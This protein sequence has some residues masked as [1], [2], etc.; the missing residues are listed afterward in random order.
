MWTGRTNADGYGVI[1][2]RGREFLVHRVAW[3]IVRGKPPE[4]MVCHHCD[5]RLCVRSSHLFDGDHASNMADMVTKRRQ[6]AGTRVGNARLI[7]ED[8]RR[9]RQRL[10][11]GEPYR[12]IALDFGVSQGAIQNI[13]C[14]RTW[15]HVT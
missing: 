4:H 5:N 13:A 14:G 8:V 3:E 15:R 7:D 1:A 9:I 12:T 2:D 11:Q 10:D 6:A